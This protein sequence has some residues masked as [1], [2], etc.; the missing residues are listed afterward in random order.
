MGALGLVE[1]IRR[2]FE[3]CFLM[4]VCTTTRCVSLLFHCTR[5]ACRVYIDG[6]GGQSRILI[7]SNGSVR[8]NDSQ[9]QG[10]RGVAA[11]KANE[12]YFVFVLNRARAMT[13][14]SRFGETR[15]LWKLYGANACRL[16]TLGIG[17]GRNFGVDK[18]DVERTWAPCLCAL[19]DGATSN[20]WFGRRRRS[21]TR[22][23]RWV[24]CVCVCVP[25]FSAYVY[26]QR[27]LYCLAWPDC[28][29]N[30]PTI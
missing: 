22:L 25:T 5:R 9:W 13:W 20:G 7:V 27:C 3:F 2:A 29:S 1:C 16:Y 19:A 17:D 23:V 28:L 8:A 15:D 4:F 11:R 14:D 24:V 26:T 30:V 21:C 6:G 10:W 18:T 12:K